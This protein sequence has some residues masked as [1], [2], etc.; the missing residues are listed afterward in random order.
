AAEVAG[1]AAGAGAQTTRVGEVT[2][3]ANAL[4]ASLHNEYGT[5][6]ALVDAA[7]A[8]RGPVV[9]WH[10][11]VEA[12]P[13]ADSQTILDWIACRGGRLAAPYTPI[14]LAVVNGMVP[15]LRWGDLRAVTA[16]W[17]EQLGMITNDNV[18]QNALQ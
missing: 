6:T 13:R 17:I 15:G 12:L 14:D 18:V 1:P 9:P 3:D 7:L 5:G 2:L 8:G 11:F 16:A 10:V 4:I